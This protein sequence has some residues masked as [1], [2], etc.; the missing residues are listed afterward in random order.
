VAPARADELRPAP[1]SG[2]R[3]TKSLSL[4]RQICRVRLVSGLRLPLDGPAQPV[5]KCDQLI[6]IRK[7]K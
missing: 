2:L 7:L 6:P 1:Y 3:S 4:L 5:T